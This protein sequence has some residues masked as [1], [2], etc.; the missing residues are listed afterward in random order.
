LDCGESSDTEFS[1]QEGD[2]FLLDVGNNWWSWLCLCDWNFF[3]LIIWTVTFGIETFLKEHWTSHS[4]KDLTLSIYMNR[5]FWMRWIVMY[6]SSKIIRVIFFPSS[7][8]YISATLYT[9]GN[10]YCSGTFVLMGIVQMPSMRLYFSWHQL[11]ATHIFICYLLGQIW[12][13]LDFCIW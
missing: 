1:E 6:S 7:A 12:K 2:G 10:V 4:T 3:F 5:K 13:R 11:V 9:I 8:R